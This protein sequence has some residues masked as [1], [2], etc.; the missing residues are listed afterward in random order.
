[1]VNRSNI[2]MRSTRRNTCIYLTTQIHNLQCIDTNITEKSNLGMLD[3]LSYFD[4]SGIDC[5]DPFTFPYCRVP[6]LCYVKSLLYQSSVFI[7]IG[8]RS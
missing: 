3:I 5:P 7:G 6:S 1:M 4:G 8:S 2:I